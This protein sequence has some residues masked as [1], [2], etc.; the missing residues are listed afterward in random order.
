[1]AGNSLGSN[2]KASLVWTGDAVTKR[3]REA[4]IRGVNGTMGACAVEAK[5]KHEWQ[6]RTTVLEGG[7][8]VVDYAAPVETGVAGTWGVRDVKYAL[9]HEVGGTIVPKNAKALAIPQ[10]DGSVRFA[11]SVTIP[12]RPYLRPAGD[13]LYP[14]LAGRIRVAYDKS[15]APA[16]GGTDG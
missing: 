14:T 13:K 7:I 12:A 8:D 4:Q 5:S 2:G 9:I 11:K 16:S 15:G 1:M 10:P 6:N 3:M